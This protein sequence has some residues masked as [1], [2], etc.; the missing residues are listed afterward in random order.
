[1]QRTLFNFLHRRKVL[2]FSIIVVLV[3][4]IFFAFI[5]GDVLMGKTDLLTMQTAFTVE[6]MDSILTEWGPA[7]VTVYL[8]LMWVDFFFP[9]AYALA[10]ASGITL[11]AVPHGK[12]TDKMVLFFM[13]LPLIA[14]VCDM[15]ENVFHLFLLQ[16]PHNLP[17]FPTII[18][19]CFASIKWVL[20]F[21]SSLTLLAY[22]FL[23]FRHRNN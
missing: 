8:R 19:A 3:C 12:T 14:G 11:L 9:A 5:Q 7:G 23:R 1:M 17:V 13:H 22:S 4:L 21:V 18:S 20:L 15:I 6:K 10:L 16:N 2:I